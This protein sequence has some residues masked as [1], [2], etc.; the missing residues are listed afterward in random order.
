[1]HARKQPY[2]Y[3][4]ADTFCMSAHVSMLTSAC[5]CVNLSLAM[6]LQVRA[7]ILRAP[8]TALKGGRSLL[9]R[10]VGLLVAPEAP[11]VR[12]VRRA[13]AACASAYGRTC[14]A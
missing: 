5:M 8:A 13:L 3:M 2:L 12:Q 9:G 10:L 1:M 7:Y 6:L 11:A 14:S 4:H